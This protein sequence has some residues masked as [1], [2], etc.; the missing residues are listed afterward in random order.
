MG[1]P[2]PIRADGGDA[3]LPTIDETILLFNNNDERFSETKK[4]R[5]AYSV[6][7]DPRSFGCLNAAICLLFLHNYSVN[8]LG[9][10]S[11]KM[12]ACPPTRP[13]AACIYLVG[14]WRADSDPSHRL[15][16]GELVAF[17]GF[18]SF[19]PG[20]DSRRTPITYLHLH[21]PVRSARAHR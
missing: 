5:Q 9:S 6:K 19:D 2:W 1:I 11:C 21:I 16:G 7:S 17:P 8:H 20:A 4:P 18:F 15:S 14:K 10:G 12:Q 13:A 3:Q